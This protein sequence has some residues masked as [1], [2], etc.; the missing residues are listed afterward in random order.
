MKKDLRFA[1][2]VLFVCVFACGSPAAFAGVSGEAD[3]N[4]MAG[5]TEERAIEIEEIT[6]SNSS[7]F[8]GALAS[9]RTVIMTPGQFSHNLPKPEAL[10]GFG[11]WLFLDF[12]EKGYRLK[13]KGLK[14]L[15]IR[16]TA[17][18]DGMGTFTDMICYPDGDCVIYFE[19]CENLSVEYVAAGRPTGSEFAGGVFSFENCS[20]VTLKNLA[21]YGGVSALKIDGTS[22]VSIK[23]SMI[24]SCVGTLADISHGTGVTFEN[25]LF[26]GNIVE[27]L[28]VVDGASKDISVKNSNFKNNTI[29]NET[30]GG[31]N[32]NFDGCTFE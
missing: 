14:N 5:T 27:K 10:P 19:D 4:G 21:L 26:T 31:E 17:T 6:V 22:G 11:K 7:E 2:A 8:Y 3:L 18:P 28:F 29:I 9:G 24:F 32:V 25:C 20:G 15:T 16:G 30:K 1:I 23:N 13:V 12:S